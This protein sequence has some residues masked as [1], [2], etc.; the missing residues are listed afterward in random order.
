MWLKLCVT[1]FILSSL[2]EATGRGYGRNRGQKRKHNWGNMTS[3]QVDGF[4]KSLRG[5]NVDRFV[6]AL[7]R[8]NERKGNESEPTEQEK[9]ELNE[10]KAHLRKHTRSPKLHKEGDDLDEVNQNAGVA[11]SLY[12]GDMVL[13]DPQVDVMLGDFV[14]DDDTEVETRKKRQAYYT[15]QYPRN[16][17]GSTFYY[18]FDPSLT[19]AAKSISQVAIAFWQNSTCINFVESQTN[20]N[21]VRFFKGSGCYSYVGMIGGVQDLSLGDG[22]QYFRQ[23]AHEIGH[24]LGFFHEQNRYDRDTA[25]TIDTAKV[26][27]AYVYAYDK[28]T[29]STNNNYNMP[30]DYGSIMQ[31]SDTSFT[32][33]GDKTMISKLPVYQDTM[34]SQSI[35]FYDISMMNEHYQCKQKCTSGATCLNGGFRNSRNCNSCICPSGYGGA[36][37]AERASGCGA[38]LTATSNVQTQEISIGGSGFTEYPTF[39]TCNYIIKAPAGNKIEIVLTKITGIQCNGGCIY[40]SIEVKALKDHRYTGMRYCCADDVN[41]KIISEGNIVPVIISNRYSQSSY[42]FTYRYVPASTAATVQMS[43]IP[44]TKATY[45]DTTN[46]ESQT[47]PP[48]SATTPKSTSTCTEDANCP[49]W[50]KNSFCT[51]TSYTMEQKR[52]YCPNSCNL[53]DVAVKTCTDNASCSAWVQNG[54]CTSS[55]YT[56]D[57][58]KQYCPNA[59]NLCN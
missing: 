9:A 39:E 59:C 24:A 26:Q 46:P 27:P 4:K 56:A 57:T 33:N 25:I 19:D 2:V 30:Y 37:C 22:C 5:T 45:D 36:T 23:A 35:S 31:Y 52:S 8:M 55:A 20:P 7:D 50:A 12:G 1:L 47:Q 48:S 58:R 6:A 38:M 28:E 3:E 51:S 18:Y 34:G 16:L 42:T 54:F 32:Q 11:N 29:T 15:S 43:Q 53:C 10:R 21:R 14:D 17:W 44:F 13:S 49:T 41:T 40:K